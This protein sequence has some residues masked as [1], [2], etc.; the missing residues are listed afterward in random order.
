MFRE[1]VADVS[2]Y[3]S[4]DATV[5]RAENLRRESPIYAI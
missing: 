5:P 2:P 1:F 4:T 3:A